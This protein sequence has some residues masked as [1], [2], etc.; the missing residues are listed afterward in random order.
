MD[1][2]S[3]SWSL[4]WSGDGGAE[5]C[6]SEDE[7]ISWSLSS[8]ATGATVH[9]VNSNHEGACHFGVVMGIGIGQAHP[10]GGRGKGQIPIKEVA[11]GN[12]GTRVGWMRVKVDVTK[13]KELHGIWA[14]RTRTRG[15]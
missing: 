2:C 12:G 9:S 3:S 4:V 15:G 1:T 14:K 13:R 5:S 7:L 8:I 6:S 10:D 11:L